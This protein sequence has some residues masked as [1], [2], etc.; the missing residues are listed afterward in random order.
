[1][2]NILYTMSLE[3][4]VAEVNAVVVSDTPVV[5]GALLITDELILDNNYE[6]DDEAEFYRDFVD[7]MNFFESFLDTGIEDFLCNDEDGELPYIKF[8]E[9]L[10]KLQQSKFAK[11][12]W[13]RMERRTLGEESQRERFTEVDK[14]NDPRFKKCPFCPARCIHIKRHINNRICRKVGTGQILHPANPSQKKKVNDIMYAATLD[15]NDVI[16]RQHLCKKANL[17]NI[18]NEELEEEEEYDE[19]IPIG[20]KVCGKTW[21]GQDYQTDEEKEDECVFVIKTWD[22]DGKYAGLWEDNEGNKEFNNYDEAILQ[23][24][25]ATDGEQ[26][27]C[28][29]SLIKINPNSEDRET[30]IYDWEYTPS[31]YYYDEEEDA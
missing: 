9:D 18:E 21:D 22:M 15:L 12:T 14:L 30:C 27:Y 4:N 20:T 31:D 13:A 3:M 26:D 7:A 2:Y 17:N 28:G 8:I 29:V 5:N 19:E 23:Y 11:R 6:N 16:V 10:H 24:E 1:M 25:Y